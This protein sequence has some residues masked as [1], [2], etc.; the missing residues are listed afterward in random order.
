MNDEA[1]C[2]GR[3]LLF[4]PLEY[5][6]SGYPQWH[7]QSQAFRAIGAV[8]IGSAKRIR[9]RARFPRRPA[10]QR[11]VHSALLRELRCTRDPTESK[12]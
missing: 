6:P 10:W 4:G 7:S 11:Q 8:A 5:A 2:E 3:Y 1:S 12:E 9:G